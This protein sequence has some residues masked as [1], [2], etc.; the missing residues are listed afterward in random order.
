MILKLSSTARN[1]VAPEQIA[2]LSVSRDET[3]DGFWLPIDALVKGDRGLWSCFAVMSSQDN[4]SEIERRHIE[5]IETKEDRVLVRGN[6]NSGDL[7]V[8]QGV[9][10]LVPGQRVIFSAN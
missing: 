8:A 6:L 5:L 9:H 10:R 3:T 2:R 7:I 4:Y 1:R